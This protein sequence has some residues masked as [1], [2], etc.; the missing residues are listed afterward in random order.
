MAKFG[1]DSH[2]REGKTNRSKH[3]NDIKVKS[4]PG[5]NEVPG[6]KMDV[7]YLFLSGIRIG[8]LHEY[9]SDANMDVHVAG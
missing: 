1:I 2:S 9:Y 7:F 3:P 5:E 6:E 8:N 4:S